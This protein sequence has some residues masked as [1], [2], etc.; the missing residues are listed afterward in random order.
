M[1]ARASKTWFTKIEL[2]DQRKNGKEKMRQS[3][4]DMAFPGRAW[5][6]EAN[7]MKIHPR[8]RTWPIF[9]ISASSCGSHWILYER[10]LFF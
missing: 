8:R 4:K 1:E 2:G 7:G 3:F 10:G 6:R 9:A 5:E